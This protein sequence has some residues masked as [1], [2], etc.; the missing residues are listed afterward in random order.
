MFDSITLSVTYAMNIMNKIQC[1]KCSFVQ[2]S[3]RD[4]CSEC[5]NMMLRSP[6]YMLDPDGNHI[7]NTPQ[8]T[9]EQH[10]PGLHNQNPSPS[11][12]T[13]STLYT[14][15][16]SHSPVLTKTV[17][18]G[19]IGEEF[20]VI[21]CHSCYFVQISQN[22]HCEKCNVILERNPTYIFSSEKLDMAKKAELSKSLQMYIDANQQVEA[23]AHNA[24]N[25]NPDITSPASTNIELAKSQKKAIG[26]ITQ[27]KKLAN[28]TFP[29]TNTTSQNNQ[30]H[31][32]NKIKHICCS[33]CYTVQTAE[34]NICQKCKELMDRD[35]VYIFYK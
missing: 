24:S 4:I 1:H 12:T 11:L 21:C 25:A 23:I 19:N 35:P 30:S 10:P 9:P 22:F 15:Q 16:H 32:D 6:Q 34:N 28:S 17:E 20:E 7:N 33:K 29:P 31:N 2:S 3:A 13:A 14:A 27:E 8:P 5:G 18:K 26:D